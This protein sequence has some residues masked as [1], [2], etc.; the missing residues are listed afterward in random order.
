[1]GVG[2][3]ARD[4]GRGL[5]PGGG[6]CGQASPSPLLILLSPVLADFCVSW[7]YNQGYSHSVPVTMCKALLQ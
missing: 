6:A 3:V 2:L 4:N 5:W 7:V 1:M